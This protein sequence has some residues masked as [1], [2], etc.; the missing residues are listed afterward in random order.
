MKNLQEWVEELKNSDKYIIVEGPNDRKSLQSFGIK[1][2]ITL[3]RKAIYKVVEELVE[4][5]DEVVILTD[6]DKEGKQLYGKLSHDLK[7][8]GIKV[9]MKFREWLF[10][11][12]KLRQIE[13]LVRYYKRTEEKTI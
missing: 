12:T 2:I 9:D 1:H 10:K 6:L 13:G 11:E 5:A 4:K 8:H 7:R 3:S